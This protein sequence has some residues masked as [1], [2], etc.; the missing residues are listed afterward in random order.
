MS[1]EASREHYIPGS[2]F[3][4]SCEKP[5]VCWELSPGTQEVLL[6]AESSLQHQEIRFKR[7]IFTLKFIMCQRVCVCVININSATDKLYLYTDTHKFFLLS[8]QSFH[9]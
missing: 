3:T 7:N 8:L 1:E 5:S 2:G 9:L 6:T 4:D